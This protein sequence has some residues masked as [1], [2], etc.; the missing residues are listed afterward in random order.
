MIKAEKAELS[1]TDDEDANIGEDAEKEENTNVVRALF[2]KRRHFFVSC[3]VASLILMLKTEF[4]Y[5]KI[6]S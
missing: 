5:T 2:W 1:D 4:S 6:F 3:L